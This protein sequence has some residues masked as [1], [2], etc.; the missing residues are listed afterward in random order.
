MFCFYN[1]HSLSS[2]NWEN[3]IIV[4]SILIL[5]SFANGHFCIC[6]LCTET[7]YFQIEFLAHFLLSMVT[8]MIIIIIII[9]IIMMIII[10]IIIILMSTFWGCLQ[11]FDTVLGG[12]R[13]SGL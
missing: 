3:N 12:R 11:C 7:Y 4:D 8:I 2:S 5:L 6:I 13:A 9:I 10:M 1:L